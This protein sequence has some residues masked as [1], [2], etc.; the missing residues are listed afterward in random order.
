MVWNIGG[1]ARSLR[2]TGLFFERQTKISGT[3]Q[4]WMKGREYSSRE[5]KGRR[6]RIKRKENGAVGT[7]REVE[8]R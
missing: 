4:N 1:A 8:S 6:K 2:M 3:N 5:K 7:W